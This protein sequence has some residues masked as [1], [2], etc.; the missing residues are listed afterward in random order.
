MSY[1]N[2]GLF[3]SIHSQVLANKCCLADT[4][5]SAHQH[6][7]FVGHYPMV[8]LA[9]QEALEVFVNE[10]ILMRWKFSFCRCLD[11][12]K[13]VGEQIQLTI[14]NPLE[15]TAGKFLESPS[16]LSETRFHNTM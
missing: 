5:R 9:I 4:L 12:A 1:R 3:R 6:E 16:K 2:L 14:L 13:L 8:A 10:V 11:M 15:E 7:L